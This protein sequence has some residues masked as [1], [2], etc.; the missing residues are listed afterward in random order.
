MARFACTVALAFVA[1]A[2]SGCGG[3]SRPSGSHAK[4]VAYTTKLEAAK[5]D[6]NAPLPPDVCFVASRRYEVEISGR[7]KQ[8]E[9]LCDAVA[10]TYL[11]DEPHLR[12]PPPYLRNPDAAPS[13]VCVLAQG[14]DHLEIDYGPADSGRLDGEGICDALV[15][16]GW[17]RRPAW[18]GLDGPWPLEPG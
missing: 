1:L 5:I 4:A 6:W 9:L 15:K 11:P 2:A 8:P 12:W 3:R 7:S 10:A 13:V 17:K 18:E 16:E 14:S